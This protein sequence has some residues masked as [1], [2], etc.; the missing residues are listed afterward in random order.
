MHISKYRYSKLFLI[1]LGFFSV[2]L[3]WALYNA[4]VPLLLNTFALSTFV[5]GFIMTIDNI[6]AVILQPYIGFLSD[7]SRSRI[8]RRMPFILIGAPLGALFFALIPVVYQTNLAWLMICIILMNLGM[9][10]FRTPVIALMPDITPSPLRSKANG[11]IN[12][13]GGLGAL[14]AYFAGGILFDVNI[15][16][17]FFLGG[18]LL[19]FTTLMLF[20]FVNEPKLSIVDIS[21]GSDQG[22]TKGFSGAFS[23]LSRSLRHLVTKK[24]KNELFL[25]LS[26]FFWF[27]GFNVIE[28][29]FTLWGTTY[30]QVTEGTAAFALGL[31]SLSFM[32]F[33]IPAGFI[34]TFFGRKRTILIGLG[35]LAGVLALIGLIPNFTVIQILLVVGGVGWALV[36]INSLPMV[37]DMVEED[38]AGGHTGLY[39]FFSMFASIAAPPLVGKV[40]DILGYSVLT[41]SSV[42]FFGLAICTMSKVHAGEARTAR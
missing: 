40:I 4:F 30:I 31:F 8:G 5:I 10:I 2:S 25:L 41:W 3:I 39:Y 14:I 12:F 37:V 1:G 26:V 18:G 21:K 36:N 24:D 7:G 16:S 15:G 20:V 42:V 11:I 22:Q 29:F 23:D 34:G 19:I 28:T 6:L 33:A 38:K 13:M 17:P 32:I 27:C 9:A 35:G